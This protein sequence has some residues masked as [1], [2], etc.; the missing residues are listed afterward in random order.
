MKGEKPEEKKCFVCQQPAVNV[1]PEDMF[2]GCKKHLQR[3]KEKTRKNLAW[4]AKNSF[5]AWL[6]RK[7]L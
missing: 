3:A 6:K 4:I 1:V 5:Q 2:F 7:P